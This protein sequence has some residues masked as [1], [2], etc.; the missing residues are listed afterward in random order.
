M[1]T[2]WIALATL[3]IVLAVVLAL[4]LAHRASPASRDACARLT[5]GQACLFAGETPVAA[6]LATTSASRA[7]G[8]SGR[9]SLQA[10]EGMLF[11]FP[12]DGTPAFWMKDMRFALDIVW[13]DAAGRV[14][15]VDAEVTPESFPAAF[16]PPSPVRYVLELG[17][18]QARAL[19]IIPGTSI[20][21]PGGLPHDAR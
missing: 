8:L 19:G 4:S 16:S 9:E 20:A 3:P 5:P 17:A 6:T 21:A 15:G 14:V 11:V 10:R 7:L 1:T 13:I 2:R 12:Q 18:G